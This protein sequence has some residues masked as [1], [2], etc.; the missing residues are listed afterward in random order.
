MKTDF[1][2]R[3]ADMFKFV[4]IGFFTFGQEGQIL[5]VNQTGARLLGKERSDLLNQKFANFMV[6]DFQ[7]GFKHHC[8]KVLE[9]GKREIYDLRLSTK[10]QSS[11]WV[12]LESIVEPA[13]DTKLNGHQLITT[14]TDITNR[15][16]VECELKD[17]R[18]ELERRVDDHMEILV[19][20]VSLS[21]RLASA[22][23]QQSRQNSTRICPEPSTGGDRC[24]WPY[25]PFFGSPFKMPTQKLS[26]RD[27]SPKRMTS[28]FG[29]H[30]T[31]ASRSTWSS[32]SHS[33]PGPW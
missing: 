9:T 7:D 21:A 18:S 24:T 19:A 13:V 29:Q 3:Y 12:Q 33:V 28:L 31:S 14:I 26:N 25:P 6:D 15:K 20:W 23:G 2:R 11:Y 10:D 4:P 30:L 16:Q 32:V 22:V 17:M 1:N 5:D 8:Q 27:G